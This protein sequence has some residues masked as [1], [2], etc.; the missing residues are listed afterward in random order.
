M[1]GQLGLWAQGQHCFLD[2]RPPVLQTVSPMLV[3]TN[4]T[5]N[6]PIWLPMK[7]A[8]EFAREALDTLGLSSHVSG[9]L[10]HAVQVPLG[11]VLPAWAGWGGAGEAELTLPLSC[12]SFLLPFILPGW[13]LPSRWVVNLLSESKKAR[14]FSSLRPSK[15]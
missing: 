4:M 11:Q 2:P 13:F 5:S 3:S 12:Q 7:D 1:L 15:T 10:W 9:C 8:D 14:R 6:M